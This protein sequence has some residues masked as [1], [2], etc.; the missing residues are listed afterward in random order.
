MARQAHSQWTVFQSKRWVPNPHPERLTTLL[1]VEWRDS[2]LH[3]SA[4]LGARPVHYYGAFSPPRNKTLRSVF[5][6][7]IPR[8]FCFFVGVTL[9]FQMQLREAGQ[10][11]TEVLSRRDLQSR[12]QNCEREGLLSCRLPSFHELLF[13]DLLY[14]EKLCLH[15]SDYGY[16]QCECRCCGVK[17]G[18]LDL[19]ELHLAV[20]C[21]PWALRME[22]RSSA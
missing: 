10:E 12:S 18:A 2:P 6:L 17:E 7:G 16:V 3:F 14:F 15:V 1:K 20:I 8:D 4:A 5:G 19:L 21:L 22:L 13:E 9:Q 11:C